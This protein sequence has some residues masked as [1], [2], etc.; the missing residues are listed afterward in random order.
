MAYA[1]DT[2]FDVSNLDELQRR[3]GRCPKEA[4]SAVRKSNR[5]FAAKLRDYERAAAPSGNSR[6]GSRHDT[7][8]GSMR[9]SIRPGAGADYAYVKGGGAR[10]P[11]LPV[12]E[13]GGGVR[14]VS[15]HGRV[16]GIP[17]KPRNAE[18]YWFFPTGKRH[19]PELQREATD[20]AMEVLKQELATI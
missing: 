20:A 12:Q 5:S 19:V 3:L 11:H 10:A 7:P 13:F 9:M 1:F 6:H 14:W 18:G 4:Q 15:K 2:K 16:H 17:I 8:P